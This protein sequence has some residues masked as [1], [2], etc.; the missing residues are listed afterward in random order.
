M[1]ACS[2]VLIK[3]ILLAYIPPNLPVSIANKGICVPLLAV[4]FD[5]LAAALLRI[6]ECASP[7]AATSFC[8]AMTRTSCPHTGASI[9]E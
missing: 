1:P 5:V 4:L 9:L 2:A 6:G 3:V 7:V 8:P